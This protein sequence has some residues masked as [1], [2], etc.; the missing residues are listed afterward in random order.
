MFP[1]YEQCSLSFIIFILI[2]SLPVIAQVVQELTPE[3]TEHGH[4]NFQGYWTNPFQTPLERPLALISR[5]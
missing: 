2:I 4:P 3:L 5:F 1:G